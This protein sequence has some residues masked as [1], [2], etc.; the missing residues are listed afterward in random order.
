MSRSTSLFPC[1]EKDVNK[2]KRLYVSAQSMLWS[3]KNDLKGVTAMEYGLLA[4]TTIV[5]GLASIGAIGGNLATVF[6][7]IN[8][9]L[10]A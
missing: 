6:A 7:T 2:M 10:A 5:V 1:D 8:S 3:L 9:G 4:A